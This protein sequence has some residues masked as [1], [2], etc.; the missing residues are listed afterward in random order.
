MIDRFEAKPSR[1]NFPTAVAFWKRVRLIQAV[2]KITQLCLQT[3]SAE[4]NHFTHRNYRGEHNKSTSRKKKNPY[5]LCHKKVLYAGPKSSRNILT[6]LSPSPAWLTT[7]HNVKNFILRVLLYLHNDTKVYLRLNQ[8][9]K[10]NQNAQGWTGKK[11][12]YKFHLWHEKECPRKQIGR[13]HVWTPVTRPSRMPS[14]AWNRRSDR[15]SVV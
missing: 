14:S 2:K 9:N 12:L 13:A 6:N 10:L 1:A 3:E 4:K 15:K 7:L 11:V 5:S 8:K